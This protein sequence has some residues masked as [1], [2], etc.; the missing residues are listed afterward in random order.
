MPIAAFP[1]LNGRG[2]IEAESLGPMAVADRAFP[3][4]NGRGLI[5]A[6]QPEVVEK[7]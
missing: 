3:R 5:E 7:P 6:G 4:L 1:R 2:L